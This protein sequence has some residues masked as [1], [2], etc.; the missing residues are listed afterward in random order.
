[1]SGIR[2][3]ALARF[4]AGLS[5][6]RRPKQAKHRLVG[7]LMADGASMSST[8]AAPAKDRGSSGRRQALG[9][10][11]QPPAQA[12]R[13]PLGSPC[14]SPSRCPPSSSGSGRPG[15]RCQVV[16]LFEERVGVPRGLE[17]EPT[18]SLGGTSGL[19][20]VLGQGS[21]RPGEV[22]HGS[23]E[24]FRRGLADWAIDRVTR[25][26]TSKLYYEPPAP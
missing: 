8:I 10:S 2:A 5:D 1:M 23:G 12:R 25:P 18:G 17:R 13:A 6:P 21:D 22:R 24:R 14:R 3:L 19:L 15:R 16:S 4:L 9:A 26:S 7:L 11:W 20:E